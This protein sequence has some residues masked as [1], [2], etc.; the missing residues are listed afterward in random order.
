MTIYYPEMGEKADQTKLFR[1][2][3][4]INSTFS[5]QWKPEHDAQ[6]R[7]ALKQLR[8][9]PRNIEQ[10]EPKSRHDGIAMWSG[11]I[12]SEACSKLTHS[13]LSSREILLD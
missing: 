10:S 3:H 4:V 7:V 6:A 1:V 5:I 11:L 8:I 2:F 12:T 9:R 13:G